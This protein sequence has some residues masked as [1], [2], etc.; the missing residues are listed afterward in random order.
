MVIAIIVILSVIS[1]SAYRAVL[2]SA[3]ERENRAILHTLSLAVQEYYNQWQDYPPMR[4][5][6]P[7]GNPLKMWG[8][9][10]GRGGTLPNQDFS[11]AVLIY[12]L[13]YVSG[14]ADL[15]KSLPSSVLVP[16][17][18]PDYFA[19]LGG[20]S[21][22]DSGPP[23][24]GESR[25]WYTVHDAWGN[26]IQYMRPFSPKYATDSNYPY[27]AA[28]LNN[29][30]LL[31]SMGKDG[32]PGTKGIDTPIWQDTLSF[33]DRPPPYFPNPWVLMQGKGDDVVVQVGQTTNQ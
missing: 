29:R 6:G 7:A 24:P 28:D 31:V 17:M 9:Q 14:A 3:Q 26:P 11:M 32:A 13:Q 18:D 10:I 16:L 1:L 30:V 27:R 33:P 8:T 25:P 19:P 4:F 21:G 5:S 20:G 23:G 15:L 22:R 12:H 2:R